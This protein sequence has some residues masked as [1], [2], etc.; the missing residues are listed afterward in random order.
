M[1]A[2]PTDQWTNEWTNE[3]TNGPNRRW[4]WRKAANPPSPPGPRP[5]LRVAPC[6]T[7]HNL[8]S[9]NFV[10]FEPRTTY[11]WPHTARAHTSVKLSSTLKREGTN[12]RAQTSEWTDGQQTPASAPAFGPFL[13]PSSTFC[14]NS[15]ITSL[16][17]STALAAITSCAEE[18]VAFTRE[19]TS[20]RERPL[21]A[22]RRLSSKTSRLSNGYVL[23]LLL[24]LRWCLRR[25]PF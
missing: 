17:S 14:S 25:Q 15:A 18:S 11:D 5:A 6:H 24:L 20:E 19:H 22:C 4:P 21:A 7:P 8:F 23:L 3:W 2:R 16:G 9:L 10:G 12:K 1:D 13:F